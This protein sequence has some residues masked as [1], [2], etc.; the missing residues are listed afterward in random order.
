MR[1][2]KG[3]TLLELLTTLAVGAILVSFAVPSFQTVTA[4]SN[5]T[6]S[7]NDL[8]SALHVARSTAVSQNTRVTV[9]ASDDGRSCGADGWHKGFIVFRDVD[10]DQTVDG[11]DTIIS[12]GGKLDSLKIAPSG[13]GSALTYRTNG[14][15]NQPAAGT[16]VGAFAF[17]DSRGSSHARAL[18]IEVSGRPRVAASGEHAYTC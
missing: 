14:R 3:F 13:F 6:G 12:S 4:N 17:C 9:C 10:S 16:I 5:Q 8:I 1:H 11:E 18:I 2:Q 7:V 15:V